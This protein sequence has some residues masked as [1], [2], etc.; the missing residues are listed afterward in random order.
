MLINIVTCLFQHAR[1]RANFGPLR[2]S[3]NN[4]RTPAPGL[5]DRP[6]TGLFTA[7]TTTTNG[8]SDQY[9]SKLRNASSDDTAI[10]AAA[11]VS[12]AAIVNRPA[13]LE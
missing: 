4:V 2:T 7:T 3:V 10:D 12:A 13:P 5:P 6:L 9:A 11:S 8:A 1:Q